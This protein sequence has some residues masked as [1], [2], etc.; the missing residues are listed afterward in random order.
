[1]AQTNKQKQNK[2]K[3]EMQAAAER[4]GFETWSQALT[5]W[6]NGAARLTLV[7]ADGRKVAA[8]KCSNRGKGSAESAHR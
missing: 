7:A 8:Q 4:D 3:A 1:M 6:K 5:A 2:R